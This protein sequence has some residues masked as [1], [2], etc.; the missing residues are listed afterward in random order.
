[1]AAGVLL[2]GAEYMKTHCIDMDVTKKWRG[3]SKARDRTVV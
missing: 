1:M 3:N 2:L